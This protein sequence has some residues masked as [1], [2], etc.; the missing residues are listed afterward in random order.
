MTGSE[1]GAAS[2]CPRYAH[3]ACP[4]PSPHHKPYDTALVCGAKGKVSNWGR[5]LED[6]GVLEQ[7]PSFSRQMLEV[8]EGHSWWKQLQ[9][10]VRLRGLGDYMR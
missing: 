6:G 9:V 10:R 8:K 1:R 7:T 5:G 3:R 4:P 2:V